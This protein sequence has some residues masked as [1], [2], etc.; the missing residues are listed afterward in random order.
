MEGSLQKKGKIYYA[1]ISLKDADGKYYTKWVSTKTGSYKK[2][3]KELYRI[4]E[5]LETEGVKDARNLLFAKFLEDWLTKVAKNKIELTTYESYCIYFKNHI[6]PYFEEKNIYLNKLSTMDLETYFNLK[7]RSSDNEDGLSVNYLKK[8]YYFMKKALDY[9]YLKVEYIKKNPIIPVE[10]PKMEN[11]LASYYSVNKLQ[12]L[13]EISKDHLLETPIVLAVHYGLRRGEVLGLRWKDINFYDKTILIANT[14]VKVLSKVEKKPKS[15]ASLRTLPMI[16]IVETH[17][18]D[19]L[20]KQKLDRKTYGSKYADNEY[21][22]K[23]RDGRPL[24]ID[25]ISGCFKD[26]LKRHKMPHIRFHDIRH[27]VA[28][29]LIKAGASIK[30]IQEWFGHSQ[31]STTLNIYSHIDVEMKRNVGKKIDNL[32]KKNNPKNK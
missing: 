2:A 9:A 20:E 31:P 14:R 28:S 8:H 18:T 22:C 10:L 27:S 21:V 12:K 25:S 3:Q 15:V 16:E 7:C 26:L 32:F 5:E 24:S 1:V 11:F 6:K 30:E 17:L 29:Y 23:Y 19:L 13:L 4:L